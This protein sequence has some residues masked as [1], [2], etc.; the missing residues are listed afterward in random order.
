MR[1]QLVEYVYKHLSH[2]GADHYGQD[3]RQDIALYIWEKLPQDRVDAMFHPDGTINE[4]RAQQMIQGLYEKRQNTL[5]QTESHDRC[6]EADLMDAFPTE[7][8]EWN[9]AHEDSY[10]ELRE[11]R[12][13]VV[14]WALKKLPLRYH[15]VLL[16]VSQGMSLVQYAETQMMAPNAARQLHHR[17]KKA[18]HIE[19][20]KAMV[21]RSL[22]RLEESG[23]TKPDL[24]LWLVSGPCV[25]DILCT[26]IASDGLPSVLDTLLYDD[27]LQ[28][29]PD[30]SDPT[31][32]QEGDSNECVA[33]LQTEEL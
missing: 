31:I 30:A 33:A 29:C 5:R 28:T 20:S 12:E 15:D 13:R 23:R 2:P 27:L 25:A 14:R 10:S 26:E 3:A 18:L 4:S 1:E 11:T 9:P 17:A 22:L 32:H 8:T 19:L 7:E 21:P 16:K 6:V 24:S